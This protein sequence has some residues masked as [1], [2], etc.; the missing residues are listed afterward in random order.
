MALFASDAY[1]RRHGE[2]AEPRE[3]EAHDCLRLLRSGPSSDAWELQSRGR[4]VSLRVRGR[5]ATNHT[6]MLLRMA[7]QGLGIALL[8]ELVVVDDVE[9]GALRRVLGGWTAPPVPVCAVTPSKVL[10]ARTRL[11]LDCLRE[12][13]AVVRRRLDEAV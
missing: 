13:I 6:G 11:L 10:P 9:S 1:L 8:D 4:R 7:R 12:H 2:P 3:L 5:M